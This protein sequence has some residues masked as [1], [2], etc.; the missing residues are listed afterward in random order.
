MRNNLFKGLV[1]TAAVYS[2]ILLPW[3]AEAPAIV[4]S[5]LALRKPSSALT[6]SPHEK[7]MQK[8]S[9][10]IQEFLKRM[11]NLEW[12]ITPDFRND[13]DAVLLARLITGEAEDCSDTE[14]IAVAFTAFNR[15]DKGVYGKTLKDVILQDYQ[16]SCFNEGT[17]SSIFLKTPLEHNPGDFFRS[18]KISRGIMEGRYKDPTHGATHYYN[19]DRAKKPSWAGIFKF[20]GKIG[21]H[22][23]YTGS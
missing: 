21:H 14:K 20:D 3:P 22:L 9:Y 4:P 19:P 2:E 1:F 5:F 15:L 17:D 10:E 16:Y 13:S 7:E 8:T 23:F 18:L 6:D 11:H 12:Y